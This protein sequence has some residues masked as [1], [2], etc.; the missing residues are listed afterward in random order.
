M[1]H[2]PILLNEDYYKF[3][4]SGRTEVEHIPVLNAE[5][6]V[7][8]KMKAWLDLKRQKENGAHVNSRDLRKHRLDNEPVFTASDQPVQIDVALDFFHTPTC[9]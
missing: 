7:P 6:I 1:R 8:F 5:H 3:L 2:F 9:K 4:L